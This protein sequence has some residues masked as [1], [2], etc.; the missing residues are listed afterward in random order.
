MMPKRRWRSTP[1][2]SSVGNSSGRLEGSSTIE[3]KSTARQVASGFLDHH[4]C[5]VDGWPW[6]MDFSLAEAALIASSGRATSMSFLRY[7]VSIPPA[8]QIT[9]PNLNDWRYARLKEA[10]LA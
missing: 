1:W 7:D 6:R 10:C 5:S 9:S 4:R 8:H 2:A 3:A